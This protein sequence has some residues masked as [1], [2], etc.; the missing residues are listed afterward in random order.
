MTAIYA[1][2]G[3]RS[4]TVDIASP[5][6]IRQVAVHRCGHFGPRSRRL[7]SA[8]PVT[9]ARNSSSNPQQSDRTGTTSLMVT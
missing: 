8:S 4:R 9:W 2:N 5:P 7:H 3:P 1:E 6:E